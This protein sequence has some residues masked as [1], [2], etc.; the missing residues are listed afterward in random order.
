GAGIYIFKTPSSLITEC[1]FYENNGKEGAGIAIL[2]SNGNITNCEF[3]LNTATYGAGAILGQNTLSNLNYVTFNVS[4]SS[5]TNNTALESGA[6]LDIIALER[7]FSITIDSCSFEKNKCINIYGDGA[8]M[9]ITDQADIYSHELATEVNISNTVIRDGQAGFSGG[10]IITAADDSMNVNINNVK[11]LNNKG[12]RT[13]G[14]LYFSVLD[15]ARLDFEL[16]NVVFDSNS[17]DL[18]TGAG[19]EL[20]IFENKYSPTYLI[21]SCMFSNQDAAGAG[22][23]FFNLVYNSVKGPEG[24]IRNSVFSNNTSPGSGG[25]ISSKYQK[26]LI[27]NT[28]FS[29]NYS[30][31]LLDQIA[32]GGG[33]IEAYQSQ[34]TVRN[35]TFDNNRSDD[36]GSSLFVHGGSTVDLENVLFSGNHGKN[37]IYS[38]DTVS[39]RNVTM[40]ENDVA[41][42]L[43]TNSYTIIQNSIFSSSEHNLTIAVPSET[44]SKGSN[45]SSDNSMS[46]VLTGYGA[47]NDMNNTDPKLNVDFVPE[48]GSPAID[49]AN[50][51]DVQSALDL[52]GNPRMQGGAIDIGSYES[53]LVAVKDAIWN[54][55]AISIYPNPVSETLQLKLE[56]SWIGDTRITI[57]NQL[58]QLVYSVVK[59]KT[60]NTE[61]F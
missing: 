12:F 8:A 21:D 5:F 53:F 61:V 24:I 35:T 47:Y 48:K 15:L 43:D 11:I 29:E 59:N 56:S 57:Y 9:T 37:A 23:A 51:D 22:G 36:E 18:W 14:G 32:N 38:R 42:E 30:L 33:A 4:G 39:L 27:E 49:A 40:I 10:I 28:L 26:L 16:H 60:A 44:I 3:N 2:N 34:I 55:P 58:G 25:A 46:E 19:I 7:G 6:G 41:L 54:D 1:N 45:I 50:P 20:D 52:A 13:G 17:T 31:G